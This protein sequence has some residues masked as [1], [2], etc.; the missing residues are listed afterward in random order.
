MKANLCR[1]SMFP[2]GRFAGDGIAFCMIIDDLES[3]VR[4]AAGRVLCEPQTPQLVASA[5]SIAFMD[6]NRRL[7]C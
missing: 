4:I 1:S 6:K 7:G 5:A 3:I 2:P